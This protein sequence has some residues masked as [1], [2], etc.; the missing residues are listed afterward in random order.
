MCQ[1]KIRKVQVQ[2]AAPEVG[3]M[4]SKHVAAPAVIIEVLHNMLTS[5]MLYKVLNDCLHFYYTSVLYDS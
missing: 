5:I 1:K 4:Q 2:H 3:K